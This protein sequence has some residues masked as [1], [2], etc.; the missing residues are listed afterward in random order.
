MTG[1][2]SALAVQERRARGAKPFHGSVFGLW[3]PED[4]AF[5]GGAFGRVTAE[6]IRLQLKKKSRHKDLNKFGKGCQSFSLDFW[7]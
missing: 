7:K 5:R 3:S 6:N 2:Q 4:M 1:K